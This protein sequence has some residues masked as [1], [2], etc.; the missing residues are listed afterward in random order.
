MG[1]RPRRPGPGRGCDVLLTGTF[2]STNW[3]EAHLKPLA[4]SPL[5]ASVRVV[6]ATPLPP[7]AKVIPIHPPAWLVRAAGAVP[8]RLLLFAWTALRAR[9]HV[10][11]GFHLLVNGLLAALLARLVGARSIYFCV[12]G[13]M[14]VLEGGIHAENRLFALLGAP[15][16]VVERRL[17]RAVSAF[18]LVITMG[19]RAA[20][21]FR[22]R[23]VRARFEV[24]PG[25]ID[26]A[27]FA[28]GA[29]PRRAD[30]LF[31]GRLAPVKCADIFL[32]A[33][34]IA[35][36]ERPDLTAAVVGDG[37][38]RPALERLA[39]DLRIADRVAFAGQ[40]KDVAAWLRGARVLVLTSESEGLP[41][42]VMEALTCG[43]PAVVADVGELADLV[44]DGVNGFLVGSRD[45]AAFA[46][47]ALE[48]LEPARNAALSRAARRSARGHDIAAARG[49]W[50][51]V[52]ECFQ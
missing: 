21:Y 33:V 31:V 34:A 20:D 6:S 42:S 30:L 27:R 29:G 28:P 9:P 39:Q 36:R 37:P 19:R 15:D 26:A 12:G 2:H 3:I 7:I 8:A 49:R 14:E 5:C 25:G 35:A 24:L 40:E 44:A 32:R 45:P 13:P 46:A 4:A 10:I 22:R 43:V 11:G 38:L 41:L 16:A 51:L 17:V 23:G 48:A 50:D 1:P 52:L 18:D 47:R